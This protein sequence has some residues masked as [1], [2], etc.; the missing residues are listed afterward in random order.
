MNVSVRGICVRNGKLFC[1]KN[2]GYITGKPNEFWCTPGGGVDDG[3][4]LVAALKRE[5]KEELGIVATVG[6]LLYIQE[7]FDKRTK[8]IY[9]EF[10]YHILNDKDFDNIN[11][12]KQRT[13]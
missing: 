6:T 8:K 9:L 10:F 11:L 3:E 4:D 7:Y 1:V 13:D 12:S 2:T 5:I